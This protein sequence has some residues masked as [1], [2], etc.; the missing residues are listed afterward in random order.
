MYEVVLTRRAHHKFNKLSLKEQDRIE[1][2]LGRLNIN[3]RPP[4]IR[5]IYGNTYRIRTGGWRIIYA[6]F[7]KDRLVLVGR[8]VR[9]AEDTYDR[10]RDLF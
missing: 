3:P 5:K 1:T 2:T 10:V 8:I 9:R 6:V 4:G 7:D